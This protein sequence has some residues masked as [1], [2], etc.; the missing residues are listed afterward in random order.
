MVAETS[1]EQAPGIL[2]LQAALA[3]APDLATAVDRT[4]D[5]LLSRQ[6]PM[7]SLYLAR[8]DRLRC[9]AQRG[10]W[11]VQDGLPITAGVAGNAYRTGRS[12]RVLAADAPD[13][14][15]AVPGIAEEVCVPIRAGEKVVGILNVES[16]D[17]LPAD[18]LS[19]VEECARLL[20][21]RLADLGGPPEESASD[22]LVR[23]AARLAAMT[24]TKE[25]RDYV[26]TAACSLARMSSGAMIDLC[27]PDGATVVAAVGAIGQRLHDVPQPDW[28]TIAGQVSRGTSCHTSGTDEGAAFVGYQALRDAGAHGLIIVPVFADGGCRALLVCAH[29]EPAAPGTELVERLELLAAHLGSCLQTVAAIDELRGRAMQDPLTGLGNRTWFLEKVQERLDLWSADP[30]RI[31]LFAVMFCDLDGFKDVNDSL[32]HAAGDRLLVTVADRMRERLY[33]HEML[34]R[35]GGDEFGLCSDRFLNVSDAFNR[36]AVLSDLLAPHFDLD[37]VEVGISASIGIAV[38]RKADSAPPDAARLLREADAAMYE[39]KRRGRSGVALFTDGLRRAATERLAIATGLRKALSADQLFL[40]YQPVVAMPGGQVV[41]VEALLRWQHPDRGMLL[42]ADF[43]FVA[44]DTRQIL[45]LGAWALRQ[46]CAE[47]ARWDALRIGELPLTIG[48]NLSARQLTDPGLPGIVRDA[49][50]DSGIDPAR[51]ILEITESTLMHDVAS[52]HAALAA[53][54]E[55]GVGIAIDDFGTGFSSLAYLKRFP[56]DILKIDG[57]F[58]EGLPDDV[59]SR[60]IV[61]AIVAMAKALGLDLVA[62]GVQTQEQRDCVTGLGCPNAQGHVFAPALSAEQMTTLLNLGP[63]E[64][65]A[66]PVG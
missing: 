21:N 52:A 58:I 40:V 14:I 41:G 5:H 27:Q 13:F 10:Y 54:K 31:G 25:L 30:S 37:G 64:P 12:I 45:E 11:Q 42:P 56:V 39:A 33:A 7:P 61:A 46:S 34:A 47:L 15:A 63:F 32:G 2:D 51:L 6:L 43:I 4:L 8:G 20:G 50:A 65:G 3:A 55:I 22:Q 18:A 1:D 48:V 49:V 19:I 23:H 28:A 66:S 62:E 24:R 17:L 29:S 35:L 60:A 53:L 59:E 44:E 26:V 38:V 16:M 36:A 57:S 9:H